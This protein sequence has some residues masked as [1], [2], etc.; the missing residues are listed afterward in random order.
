MLIAWQ[1]G[2]IIGTAPK[3]RIEEGIWVRDDGMKKFEIG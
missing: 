3:D 2:N 1:C